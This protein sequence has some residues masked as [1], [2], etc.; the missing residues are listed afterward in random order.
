[1]LQQS[2]EFVS[3]KRAIRKTL[4]AQAGANVMITILAILTTP[5]P[6]QA[7]HVMILC[8]AYINCSSQNRQHFCNFFQQK[9][10]QKITTLVP[11]AGF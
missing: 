4:I 8:S 10:L 11:E 2:Q 9:Y 1:L 5:R 3:Q 6:K 7:T